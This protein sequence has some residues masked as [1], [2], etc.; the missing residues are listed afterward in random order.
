MSCSLFEFC[1]L[2]EFKTVRDFLFRNQKTEPVEE[3]RQTGNVSVGGWR[4]AASNSS[5][6]ISD[7]SSQHYKSDLKTLWSRGRAAKASTSQ[8]N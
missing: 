5:D 1:R 4:S 8:L 3:K 6:S 2:Q 7:S